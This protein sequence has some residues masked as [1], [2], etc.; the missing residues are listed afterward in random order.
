[1]RTQ[2]RYTD[3]NSTLNVFNLEAQ[4]KQAAK[5]ILANGVLVDGVL[6]LYAT[7]TRSEAQMIMFRLVSDNNLSFNNVLNTARDVIR[8]QRAS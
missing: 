8:T 3:Y 1:M 4:A 2:V 7:I 6:V 5:S